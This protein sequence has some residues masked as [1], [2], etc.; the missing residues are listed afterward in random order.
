MNT[1]GGGGGNH[2]G[3]IEPYVHRHRDVGHHGWRQVCKGGCVGEC[4]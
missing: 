3:Q 4:D 1:G 2:P